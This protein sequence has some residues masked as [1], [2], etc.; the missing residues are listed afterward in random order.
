MDKLFEADYGEKL[1]TLLE[2][3]Y[4]DGLVSSIQSISASCL[5][6]TVF[7]KFHVII[8]M[9][10]VEKAVDVKLSNFSDSVAHLCSQI[11]KSILEFDASRLSNLLTILVADAFKLLFNETSEF[12]TIECIGV[13][14]S[15]TVVL[16]KRSSKALVKCSLQSDGKLQLSFLKSYMK[17]FKGI[18]SFEFNEEASSLS[19]ASIPQA[20]DQMIDVVSAFSA[21]V[22]ESDNHSQLK[23]IVSSVGLKGELV[24]HKTFVIFS[25]G[26]PSSVKS[27]SLLDNGPSAFSLAF[28]TIWGTYICPTGAQSIMKLLPNT[29]KLFWINEYS[30]KFGFES[31]MTQDFKLRLVEDRNELI[32]GI[33]EE[34]RLSTFG[35]SRQELDALLNGRE[36]NIYSFFDLLNSSK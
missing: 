34:F 7:E 32:I 14:D 16:A 11:E 17:P 29:I 15:T 35:Q 12:K 22:S 18:L 5:Q 10:I 26:L 25:E 6:L 13:S 1:S 2:A 33:D 36:F 20:L 8:T 27:V 19:L 24:G 3:L 21:S 4:K 28:D 31:T 9:K 30:A 23:E